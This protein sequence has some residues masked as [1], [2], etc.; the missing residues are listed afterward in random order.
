MSE[1]TGTR[2]VDHYIRNELERELQIHCLIMI[3]FQYF[4]VFI[5]LRQ[6]K[7]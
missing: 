3:I 7:E 1:S 4:F 2:R 5:Y 6:E